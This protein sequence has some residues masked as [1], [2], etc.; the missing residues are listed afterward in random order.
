MTF[1]KF[2]TVTHSTYSQLFDCN[3]SARQHSKIC[4]HHIY[5]LRTC[6]ELGVL[7]NIATFVAP[8]DTQC[9][10]ISPATR[11]RLQNLR[12]ASAETE[13]PSVSFIS[14]SYSA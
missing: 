13:A 9:T 8:I 12:M 11:P 14:R 4:L 5:T 6:L 1:L 10:F 3:G 2:S 7:S